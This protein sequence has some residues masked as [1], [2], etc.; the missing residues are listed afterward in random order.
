MTK[1]RPGFT[2]IELLVVISIIALLIGLLLPALASARGA[3]REM[4][5]ATNI[6]S[7]GQAV[8]LYLA[9]YDGV[10]P[11]APSPGLQTVN[12]YGKTGSSSV[13][14]GNVAAESRLLYPYLADSGETALCPFDRGTNSP[15]T[16]SVY[17][18]FGCSYIYLDRSTSDLRARD[19]VWALEG[20]RQV[21][22]NAP[23]RKMLLS[24]FTLIRSAADAENHWHNDGTL[25]R[26]GM[27]FVDGHAG[28]TEYKNDGG[29]GYVTVT[30]A[31]IDD[32]QRQDAYY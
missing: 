15:A 18:T 28:I 23:S 24:D 17:D 19:N 14:G 27:V 22:V 1:P 10:F 20:H 7:A 26:G 29:A 6:R 8:A 32:W 25:L 3:A 11:V 13:S 21:E 4:G 31:Q 2:L 12:L 30:Q 9:D 5:C 16:D